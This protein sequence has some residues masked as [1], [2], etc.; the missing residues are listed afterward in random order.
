[1]AENTEKAQQLI[2]DEL[3]FLMRQNRDL[4]VNRYHRN[5]VLVVDNLECVPSK[6]YTDST[7]TTEHYA[8]KGRRIVARNVADTLRRFYPKSF[9]DLANSK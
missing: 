5:G 2:G 1:M 7:W 4:L 8:E 3:T 9:V 6:E